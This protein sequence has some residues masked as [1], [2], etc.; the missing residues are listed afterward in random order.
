VS[1]I[2]SRTARVAVLLVWVTGV[3]QTAWVSHRFAEPSLVLVALVLT[4]VA[5]YLISDPRG[6]DPLRRSSARL[7][8][9]ILVV[10]TLLVL[11]QID[12]AHARTMAWT[13]Q[14][15][16]YWCALL[17]LVGR[18]REGGVGVAVLSVLVVTWVVTR[19]IP[20]SAG[21]AILAYPVFAYGLGVAWRVLLERNIRTVIAHRS[22]ERRSAITEAAARD[23]IGRSQ[24]TLRVIDTMA[25]GPLERI[26]V[27]GTLDDADRSRIRLA[28]ASVRDRIRARRLAVDPLAG[29]STAARARGVEVLLLDDDD[30]V[31]DS[32]PETELSRLA[33][34]VAG[35]PVGRVVIR[36]APRGGPA[37][38]T[39]VVDDGGSVVR[40]VFR[41]SSPGV[42]GA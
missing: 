3:V 33:E 19:G 4:L 35:V 41:T 20:G 11:W 32:V 9:A 30:D 6:G 13:L 37:G 26:T 21:F 39:M 38:G 2:R 8:S 31:L 25:R 1:G 10:N 18:W 23:A 15:G 36:L 22:A 28:E 29:A 14:V 34:L 40:H 16:A 27:G 7:I 12:P 5:A 24:A 42:A 17:C